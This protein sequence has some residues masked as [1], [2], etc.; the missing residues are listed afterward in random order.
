MGRANPILE[1]AMRNGEKKVVRLS[2]GRKVRTGLGVLLIG[3]GVVGWMSTASELRTQAQGTTF[4]VKPDHAESDSTKEKS[5]VNT[6]Q[7]KFYC[8]TKALNAE[9]RA[10]HKALTDKLMVARK[11]I[12]ETPKGY[13]FQFSPKSV[14]LGELTEWVGAES[15]CCPFF[16]FHIDLEA[17][18]S[19]LCLRLT[20]E[21]GVKAFIRMEFGIS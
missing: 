5:Q 10:R 3:A 12:V 14:T 13:E 11:E 1:E 7:S 15:K 21:E 17:E 4:V 8:N 19:L 9:E 6:V 18:G 16:D 20:G 2:S